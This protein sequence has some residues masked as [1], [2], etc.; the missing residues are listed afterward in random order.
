MLLL[1]GT[2]KRYTILSGTQLC[3]TYRVGIVGGTIHPP[4]APSSST[5][6]KKGEC[7]CYAFK[8]KEDKLM[9]SRLNHWSA[10]SLTL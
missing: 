5:C 4:S 3:R 7:E 1:F 2:L 9:C 6:I 10:H 8:K